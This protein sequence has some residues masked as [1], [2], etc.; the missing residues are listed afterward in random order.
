MTHC[1]PEDKKLDRS[2]SANDKRN[3]AIMEKFKIMAAEQ[4]SEEHYHYY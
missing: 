2:L 3:A 1:F 4:I